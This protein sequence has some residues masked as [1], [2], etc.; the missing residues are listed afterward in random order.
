MTE[1]LLKGFHILFQGL[2]KTKT[3]RRILTKI[4]LSIN[5]S[6]SHDAFALKD[7]NQNGSAIMY[8]I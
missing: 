4:P 8:Y 2:S 6:I 3:Q 7:L 1:L 5:T